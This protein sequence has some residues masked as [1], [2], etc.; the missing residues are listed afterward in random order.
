MRK[1]VL[2]ALF[3]FLATPAVANEVTTSVA[4]SYA[5]LDLSSSAGNATLEG[6]ISAAVNSV[7]KRPNIRDLKGM[8]SWEACKA[9]A[10]AAIKSQTAY[11]AAP[12]AA[13]LASLR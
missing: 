12:A 7:C 5:D 6:R 13:Q 11:N 10:Q 9:D 3:A 1:F 2:V 4:V 8:Q